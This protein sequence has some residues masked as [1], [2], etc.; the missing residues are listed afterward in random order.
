MNYVFD[1]VI[2]FI[3]FSSAY[4]MYVIVRSFFSDKRNGVKTKLMRA[5]ILFFLLL[6]FITVFGGSFIEPRRL[7][8]TPVNIN[9]NKTPQTEQIKIALISDFHAGYYKRTGWTQKV[10]D[11]IIK[12]NPDVVLLDGDFI[13]R[14]ES[15]AQ[16]LAPLQQLAK[17]FP[18]FAVTGNHEFNV[19]VNDRSTYDDR[20]GLLRELFS[21]WNIRLLDNA[22]RSIF[23]RGGIPIAI[24]GIEDL[25][26]G[27][28]DL[29]K[30]EE[31]VTVSPK[32]LLAHNPDVIKDEKAS[33]FD[34][35]LS[36][37]T[38]AG[39]FRL[40]GIGPIVPI[41][42]KLGRAFDYG[43]FQ[44]KNGYLFVTAGAGETGARARLFSR[45]EIV[46]INLDL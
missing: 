43:L 16:Y 11:R 23:A 8:V 19:S 46:L 34:L 12:L 40:P 2:F 45:P 4:W 6:I 24:C 17:N 15:A 28:A 31:G 33:D 36:G 30:A 37:H 39:Q 3:L 42:D 41:P 29:G 26:T 1:F 44:L 20:T 27:R 7:A 22:N 32:I 13:D 21:K 14:K 5:I 18:T 9:L 10:V 25:W 35:I 38:H